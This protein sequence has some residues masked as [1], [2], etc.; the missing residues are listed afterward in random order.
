VVQV[1]VELELAE[2]VR[3]WA[4]KFFSDDPAAADL[5][6]LVAERAY[7]DGASVSES[8]ERAMAVVSSRS[9]HPSSAGG[10]VVRPDRLA[11]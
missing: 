8:C 11:S 1:T 5:A 10:S 3:G 4:E 7:E 2:M 6:V 9:R